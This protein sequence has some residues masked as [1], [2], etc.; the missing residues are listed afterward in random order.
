M[1][2]FGKTLGITT[3]NVAEYKAVL[4]AFDWL[5]EEKKNI[6]HE[7]EI[8]FFM[9]SLLVVSQINGLWKMKNEVLRG[10][11][12]DIRGREARL[13]MKVIYAHVRREFNKKA[14]AQVNKALDFE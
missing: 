3:N 10:I 11:L 13:G 12:I 7:K 14:D 2:S 5:I 8:H 4:A 1:A 9:D 6:A